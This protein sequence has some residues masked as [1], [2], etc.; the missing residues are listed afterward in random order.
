[1]DKLHHREDS[2]HAEFVLIGLNRLRHIDP[3]L[4]DFSLSTD[5]CSFPCHRSVLCLFSSFFRAAIQG[6]FRESFQHTVHLQ[7][8]C[9][10]AVLGS[11]CTQKYLFST[12][13]C[14]V[15]VCF[16]WR[17]FNGLQLAILIPYN[18]AIRIQPAE[19]IRIRWKLLLP[20]CF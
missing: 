11:T 8:S 15:M 13:E 20:C 3:K 17:E 19:T 4:C 2:D 5:K 1:M 14:K 9:T 12:S 7:V 18:F 16:V 6:G 10:S